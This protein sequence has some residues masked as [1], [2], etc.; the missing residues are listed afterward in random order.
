MIDSVG[1]TIPEAVKDHSAWNREYMTRWAAALEKPNP[2]GRP[3]VLHSCHNVGCTS[4]FTGP[5]LAVAPCN[6]TDPK[7]WWHVPLN[8]TND[9]NNQPT[10]STYISGM[11]LRQT[12]SMGLCV[13]CSQYSD[14]C[15]NTA[16]PSTDPGTLGLG[17]L[18]IG[19]QA[20]IEFNQHFNFSL[21]DSKTEGVLCG[22]DDNCL[23]LSTL[24]EAVIRMPRYTWGRVPRVNRH[25]T[26]QAVDLAAGGTGHLV[27]SANDTS[28]CLAEGP[29]SGQLSSDTVPSP[30]KPMAFPMTSG[31]KP[32]DQFCPNASSMWRSSTVRSAAR[33]RR[34]LVAAPVPP[35]SVPPPLPPS[36][37]VR[38]TSCR[39]GA[40]V[41]SLGS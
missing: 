30:D 29:W 38:R 22:P 6:A 4:G 12:G 16:N 8:D 23:A 14:D 28:L 25:W 7:Q 10:D 32:F 20:C 3:V 33:S 27:A 18:G 39:S 11:H 36:L 37:A 34:A 31:A 5:T 19:M 17:G 1:Q 9:N 13:G 2:L 41:G 15:A 40:G 26:L 35:H 21:N 24:G